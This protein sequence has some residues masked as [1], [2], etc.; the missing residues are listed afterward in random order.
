MLGKPKDF[1]SKHHRDGADKVAINTAA[2]KR[3]E[4]IS[5][6]ARAFGSQCVALSIEAKRQPHDGWEGWG[7]A[8]PRSASTA[9]NSP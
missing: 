2:L 6:A 3:P 1:P 9:R 8:A 4:F 7:C 5:E